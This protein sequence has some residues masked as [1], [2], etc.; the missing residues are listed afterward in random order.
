MRVG[1]LCALNIED[2]EEGTAVIKTEKTTRKRRVFWTDETAR[3]VK[4]YM[5]ARTQSCQR[6]KL[7]SALFIGLKEISEL[8]F[9]HGQWRE[10]LKRWY[11]W[12]G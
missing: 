4:K 2:M 5:I 7:T 8:G 3:V 12:L 11:D 6:A 1:E 9:L 10:W